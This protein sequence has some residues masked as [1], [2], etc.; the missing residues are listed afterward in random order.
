M[1]TIMGEAL[2][3]RFGLEGYDCDWFP[4]GHD[5]TDGAD[6]QQLY[7]RRQRYPIAGHVR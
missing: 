5:A 3:E 2:V 1:N 7:A 6:S 4:R